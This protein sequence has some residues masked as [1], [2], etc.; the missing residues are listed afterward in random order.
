MAL[1]PEEQEELRRLEAKYGGQTARAPVSD[2]PLSEAEQ[3]ELA[4]LEAKYG[5]AEPTLGQKAKHIAKGYGQM[6]LDLMDLPYYGEQLIDAGLKKIGVEGGLP[7][8]TSTTRL[9]DYVPESWKE[10]LA[11]EEF[12]P[13]AA[14]N[15]DALRTGVE[16]FGAGPIN[17]FRKAL[18]GQGVMAGV[19]AMRPDLLA[20]GGAAT[21]A[22][23]ADSD[24]PYGELAG[25]T[26]GTLASLRK[27]RPPN[28]G[29]AERRA[30]KFIQK[31]SDNPAAVVA[32]TQDAVTRGEV[33]TLADLSGDQQLYNVE[34]GLVVDAEARPRFRDMQA[35]RENQQVNAIRETLG[36]AAPE[37]AADTAGNLVAGRKAT[38]AAARENV[39]GRLD[40]AV[41]AAEAAADAAEAPLRTGQRPA[42]TSA[43][44]YDQTADAKQYYVENTRRPAWKAFEDQPPIPKQ[45]IKDAVETVRQSLSPEAR[46]VFDRRYSKLFRELADGGDAFDPKD[47]QAM[48]ADIKQTLQARRAAPGVPWRNS[49]QT[50]QEIVNAMEDAMGESNDLFRLAKQATT[51]EYRMFGGV[52]DALRGEPEKFAKTLGMADEA[53]DVTVRNLQA[54]G[55]TAQQQAK[56]EHLKALAM[57]EGLDERFLT[58]YAAMIESLPAGVR[59]QFRQAVQAGDN[60]SSVL[61]ETAKARKAADAQA[62][63][64]EKAT[65]KSVLARYSQNPN[66]ELNRLLT[67]KDPTADLRRLSRV[68]ENNGQSEAFRG[69][70]REWLTDKFLRNTSGDTAILARSRGDFRKVRDNLVDSGVLSSGQADYIEDVLSSSARSVQGRKDALARHMTRAG[71]EW[72]NLMASSLAAVSL[73]AMPGTQTLLVGGA[74]RRMFKRL[75]SATKKT[76]EVE[77][78]ENFVLNPEM[79][80]KAAEGAKNAQ[81]AALR[82]FTPLVGASQ[83]AEIVGNDLLALEEDDAP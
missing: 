71:S 38:I 46:A 30:F 69:H 2:A 63:R 7:G 14:P 26:I 21:G 76:P 50:L 45:P 60:A 61:K 15:A 39:E 73:T 77:A 82:I 47:F 31:N 65:D 29:A 62:T 43:N 12:A 27:P 41:N 35:G 4:A 6:A 54:T 36:D 11:S 37:A 9:S 16:W 19:R 34:R 3:Q 57:R 66:A 72:E 20:G 42:Q 10:A 24:N 83:A 32:N 70:V 25:G 48:L 13:E 74:V 53:G 79:Y 1:T 68:M 17:F 78:L 5:P 52:N 58:K 75:L 67:S 49:E 44:L 40:D 18:T 56:L 80:L 55:A 64:L 81:D 59:D 51:E 33:G 8:E 23:L 28:M 22:A